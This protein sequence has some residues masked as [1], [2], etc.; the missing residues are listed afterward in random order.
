MLS[1]SK[2]REHWHRL[3]KPLE[4][5]P[6]DGSKVTLNGGHVRTSGVQ[7]TQGRHLKKRFA[8]KARKWQAALEPKDEGVGSCQGRR[9]GGWYRLLSGQSRGSVALWTLTTG[10]WP[11]ILSVC[12]GMTCAL[13]KAC[14]G[15]LGGVGAGEGFPE[16]GAS[17]VG[18]KGRQMTLGPSM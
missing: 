11:V 18:F 16:E 15:P 13:S 4:W 5:W 6:G 9:L 17:E 14:L 8:P 3:W 7:G 10:S 2:K 1:P 12:L